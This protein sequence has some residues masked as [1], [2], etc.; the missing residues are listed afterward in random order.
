MEFPVAERSGTVCELCGSAETPAA[1]SIPY[2]GDRGS[3]GS[4]MLCQSCLSQLEGS[5]PVDVNHWRCLNES[6][7]SSVPAVQVV[8]FRMLKQLTGESWAQ[9]L[10]ETVYRED[11]ILEWAQ[12]GL[13][14]A[15]NDEHVP[16]Q[17][18]DS[19]GTILCSG[20]TVTLIKD[21]NVKGGGFTAKRGTVVKNI[22]LTDNPLHVEGKINGTV[23]VLVAAFL[24][25]AN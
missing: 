8:S 24:K 21:L 1:Y 3:D 22:N 14:A 11:S 10:L 25:K 19:N 18:V 5:A 17:T 2:S 16:L 13:P 12:A 15:D 7:W 4:M 23:I 6:I 20:D 9:Q